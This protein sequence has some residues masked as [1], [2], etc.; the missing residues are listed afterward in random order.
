M[1]GDL[2]R[3]VHGISQDGARELR[4]HGLTPAQYRLLLAVGATPGCRQHELG[5]LLGVTKGNVSMLVSRLEQDGLVVRVPEGAAH[6]LQLTAEGTRTLARLR[7]EHSR[8]MAERFAAL[9]DA[10]LA[11]LG[12]LV[13]RLAGS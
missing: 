6:A 7:P 10:E 9:D 11:A 1:F 8:F 13:A 12:A 2:L 3:V 4:R 5:D